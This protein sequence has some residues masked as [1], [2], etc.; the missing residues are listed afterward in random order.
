MSIVKVHYIVLFKKIEIY[1]EY[2]RVKRTKGLTKLYILSIMFSYRGMAKFG[3]ALGSGP[4]GLGFESRYSDQNCGNGLCH[5]HN[6]FIV[7][8][9][10]DRPGRS[11]GKQQSGG[12]LLRSWEN[13]IICECI[14]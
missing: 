11:E 1:T 14:P 13:P 2:I 4:R 5:S 3:I 9:S 8:D 10:K 12:L 6:F 7:R